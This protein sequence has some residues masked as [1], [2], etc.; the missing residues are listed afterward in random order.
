MGLTVYGR[1]AYPMI[2]V[3]QD[4]NGSAWNI[5]PVPT[6][7]FPDAPSRF[8]FGVVDG[9]NYLGTKVSVGQR[10]MFDSNQA[11][12]VTQAEVTYYIM[13]ENLATAFIENDP[14][15]P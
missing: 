5:Y 10:I 2:S 3:A 9:I 13:D 11:V 14:T 15:P 6:A 8:L 4:P 7:G 1:L 12:C